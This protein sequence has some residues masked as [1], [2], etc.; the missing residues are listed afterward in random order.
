[1][2]FISDL[3]ELVL[4]QRGEPLSGITGAILGDKKSLFT[5]LNNFQADD[6]ILFLQI[7]FERPA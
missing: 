3:L 6:I 5:W 7:P 2:P 1:M 4:D